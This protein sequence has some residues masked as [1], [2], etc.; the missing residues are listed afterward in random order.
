MNSDQIISKI[1]PPMTMISF[2]LLLVT[3]MFERNLESIFTIPLYLILIAVLFFLF[4]VFLWMFKSIEGFWG[5]D[6]KILEKAI[7]T[8]YF[9]GIFLF[10]LSIAFL[11]KAVH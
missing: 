4:A 9:L 10:I 3:F 2:M 6:K 5:K 7:I 11:I 8:L 1:A